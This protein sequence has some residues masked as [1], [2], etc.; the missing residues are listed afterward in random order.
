M[1]AEVIF[2]Q[3]PDL[4]D[5]RGLSFSIPAEILCELSVRD[6]HIASIQPGHVRGNHYHEKKTEL[7]TVIYSDRWTFHWDTGADTPVRSREFSGH[8]AFSI[9]VPLQWSHAVKNDGVRDLW[10]FNMTDMPFD[11][12]QP[13]ATLDVVVRKIT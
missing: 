13:G 10:L 11:P 9:E 7:I 6:V 5:E 1:D 2:M 3:L 12:A 4:T 8:G